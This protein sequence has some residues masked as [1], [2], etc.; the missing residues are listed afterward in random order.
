M[1]CVAN[2][3]H[4]AFRIAQHLVIP[5]PDHPI[6]ATLQPWRTHQIATH[7]IGVLPTVHFDNQLGFGTKEID[8]VAADRLLTS[9]SESIDLLV[10]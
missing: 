10:L 4:N 2:G 3:E 9:K 7:G 5:E 1:K 6:A 8:D